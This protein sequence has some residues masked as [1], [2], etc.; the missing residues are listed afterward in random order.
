MTTF[1]E[2]CLLCGERMVIEHHEYP[3]YDTYPPLDDP[4]A[5]YVCANPDC[6]ACIDGEDDDD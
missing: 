6:P 3:L 2:F 5:H 4:H 1:S